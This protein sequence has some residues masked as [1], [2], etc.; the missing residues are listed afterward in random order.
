M[1]YGKR[2][3]PVEIRLDNQGQLKQMITSADIKDQ[4]KQFFTDDT[5]ILSVD[6]ENIMIEFEKL[7]HKK[8]K[9]NANLD[10][11]YK[12]Q[13]GL[14]GPLLIEPQQIEV[15]GPQSLV[16]EIKQVNTE[17]ISLHNIDKK[18]VKEVKIL[19]FTNS[20]INFE[21]EK[22]LL[23][24]PAEKLTEGTFT[25]PV[26]IFHQGK[27]KI[28]LIPDRITVSCQ[29]PLN[30]FEQINTESFLAYV[31]ATEIGNIK[32]KLKVNLESKSDFI[33]F[34]KASPDYI[35]FIIEK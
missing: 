13:F 3:Y 17:F 35:D 26:K 27:T 20:G 7:V 12:K 25:L 19:P 15:S 14:A 34:I 22:I 21:P 29:I 1:K 2:N 16:R 32:R 10:L 11:K 4:F 5:K 18:I 30:L 6:P 24:I 23:T 28:T 9:V 33:Y 8:V 31:D